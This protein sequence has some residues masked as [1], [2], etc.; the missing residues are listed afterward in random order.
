MIQERLEKGLEAGFIN[1]VLKVRGQHL[2][3]AFQHLEA[4]LTL[5]A[6]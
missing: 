6:L 5:K 3:H 1:D 2:L 4:P